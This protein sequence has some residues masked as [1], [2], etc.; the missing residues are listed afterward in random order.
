[1]ADPPQKGKATNSYFIQHILAF[2]KKYSDETPFVVVNIFISNS[3][4][5]T[6]F[7]LSNCNWL[8]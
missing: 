8:H 4:L 2:T 5:I 1:M 6:C 3:N 7:I